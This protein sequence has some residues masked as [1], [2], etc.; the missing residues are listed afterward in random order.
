MKKTSIAVLIGL[1]LVLCPTFALAASDGHDHGGHDN[2]AK[3]DSSH[4]GHDGMSA[5]GAMIIVCLRF[6]QA[7]APPI[8]LPWKKWG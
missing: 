6:P 1:T 7:A 3:E 2:G 8:M 4:K 5:D